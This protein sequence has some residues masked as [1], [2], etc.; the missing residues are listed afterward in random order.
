MDYGLKHQYQRKFHSSLLFIGEP[1]N[2]SLISIA[3]RAASI[4]FIS[5]EERR[6]SAAPMFSFSLHNLR[7]PGMGTIH[8]FLHNIQAREICAGV[9]CFCSAN[10][11]R[12]ANRAYAV[13][14]AQIIHTCF[15]KPP[16]KNLTLFYQVGHHGCHRLRLHLWTLS[17]HSV[18]MFCSSY[19]DLLLYCRE[20]TAVGRKHR[21][22][23]Y[24]RT[25]LY[26]HFRP[27][28]AKKVSLLESL[29]RVIDLKCVY[30]QRE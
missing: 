12:R 15:R 4:F 10:S 11:S 26:S 17:V 22:K 19:F 18:L 24:G 9:A 3:S 8:G 1:L 21:Y 14:P 6:M 23:N 20:S 27:I 16:M 25:Y 29:K 7:V 13:R 2:T 5:S 30:L 28:N